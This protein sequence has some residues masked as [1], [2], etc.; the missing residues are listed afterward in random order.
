MLPL[1]IFS[2][3]RLL[4]LPS[5]LSFLPLGRAI[6][7]CP[8]I[9]FPPAEIKGLQCVGNPSTQRSHHYGVSSLPLGWGK[10]KLL[11]KL[12]LRDTCTALQGSLTHKLCTCH[13][14]LTVLLCPCSLTISCWILEHP[15]SPL[16]TGGKD[17]AKSVFFFLSVKTSR[18]FFNF[19]S[20]PLKKHFNLE[21]SYTLTDWLRERSMQHITL[22]YTYP[23]ISYS[24][25]IILGIETFHLK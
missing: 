15:G 20:P 22:I 21:Q 4:Y 25:L 6:R 8:L 18:I 24:S 7:F 9:T 13:Y 2:W 5:T 11:P 3:C 14:M 23:L 16:L 17:L 1:G 19:P 12:R 10:P